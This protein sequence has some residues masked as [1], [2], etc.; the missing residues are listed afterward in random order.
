[1]RRRGLSRD[2]RSDDQ[3]DGDSP[4][5]LHRT[6]SYHRLEQSQP[7][8]HRTSSSHAVP[9]SSRNLPISN[10]PGNIRRTQ[11]TF[12]TPPPSPSTR[13][14]RRDEPE[15]SSRKQYRCEYC[16]LQFGRKHHKE[17]HVANIHRQVLFFHSNPSS[18]HLVQRLVVLTTPS[19]KNRKSPTFAICAT[20]RFT[21]SQTWT[22][23]ARQS[24][25][26]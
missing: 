22:V 5:G 25:R 1:M 15:E 11:S 12:E 3:S 8:P 19:L 9:N 23:T 7:N 10:Q 6:P 21:R 18:F 14:R 20:T 16:P 13:R 17:R 2:Q 4:S 26:R 24:I